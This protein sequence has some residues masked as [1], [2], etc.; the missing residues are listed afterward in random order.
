[1]FV[2][3][4]KSILMLVL[5][6]SLTSINASSDS[7]KVLFSFPVQAHYPGS[8][9]VF[10]AAGNA[11][12]TT[13]GGG[14]QRGTVY[15]LSPTSGFHI[16]YAFHGADGRQP[17]GNITLDA[18][19]NIYGA[20]FFG[21][22]LNSCFGYGCGVVFKLSPPING[23]G[24]TETVLY[25]FTGKHDGTYP[26][27]GI[28]FDR[29]GNLYGT[30]QFGGASN[31]GVVFE[32]T[33]TPV[34]WTE[35]VLYSFGGDDGAQ[36]LGR[37]VLDSAGNLYGTTESG[38]LYGRGTVFELSP[39]DSEVG[40]WKF[41]LIHSFSPSDGAAPGAGLVLDDVG[42][43][44]GTT[45]IG[46]MNNDGNVF[47]LTPGLGDWTEA[48]LHNFSGPDGASPAADLMLDNS[49]N[50][51]GTTYYGGDGV[52]TVF[53]LIRPAPGGQWSERS[54]AFPADGHLGA[55][56]SSPVTLNQGHLYGTASFGG[57][58]NGGYGVV[59]RITR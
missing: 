5:F 50:L 27:A 23:R 38:G 30:T 42:N 51:Y 3:H 36:P 17:Q 47:E 39:N 52:G 1:M 32:L 10:D 29:A 54:F 11:Y 19:G 7:F 59:F 20:T 43:L 22:D 58:A 15:Q 53:E 13:E 40:Q 18:D 44:Y 56:P 55:H 16:I 31:Q 8:G 25:S 26:Y 6:F 45:Q 48:V 33:P 49:G 21:G 4:C 28:V 34:G 2:L 24:W 12:G 57:E 37:I 14:Y 41:T 9:L 46:G 35:N